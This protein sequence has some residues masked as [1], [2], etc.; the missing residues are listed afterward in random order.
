MVAAVIVAVVVL[1]PPPRG[2]EAP[3]HDPIEGYEP[4]LAEI[5]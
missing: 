1:Q 5:V 4:G 2:D 3:V